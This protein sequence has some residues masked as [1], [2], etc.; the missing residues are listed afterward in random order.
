MNRSTGIGIAVVTGSLLTIAGPA[1]AQ[2]THT[3][4]LAG[5]SF[6]PTDRTINVGDTVH[7]QWLSGLHN[8]ES[9]VVQ[10]SV[11]AHDGNFRSGDPTSAPG[12]TFELTFDAA[13]LAAKP[14]PGNV[15]PYFCIVHA[16][17][18]MVGSITVQAGG[19]TTHSDCDDGDA[20]TQDVCVSGNCQNNAIEGC[21]VT[22]GECDD[23]NPCT[24]DAC[25]NNACDHT[26][27]PDCCVQDGDCQDGNVCTDDV[28]N[29]NV[30]GHTNNTASCDDG[31]SCTTG[32]VCSGGVCAGAPIDCD[33]GNTCTADTCANG[34]CDHAAIPNCCVQDGDCQD[35]NVCTDDVC[36]VNVCEHTNNTASCVDGDT[37]TTG[38]VCSGGV[39]AGA[40]IDCG[41]GDPCT[42]D[43]CVN[44]TCNHAPISD[45]CVQEDDCDDAN[46]CTD[47]GCV[48]NKC[49]H[50]LI[51]D[52]THCTT[53][54]ACDD[55]DECTDDACSNGVC[56]FAPIEGCAPTDGVVEGNDNGNDP[57]TGEEDGQNG[58]DQS[59]PANVN[60]GDDNSMSLS[61]E[62]GDGVSDDLDQCS[63]T[64]LGE[65]VDGNGCSEAQAEMI[66]E[67]APAPLPED[68]VLDV[69]TPSLLQFFCGLFGMITFLCI[70]SG[71][72]GFRA[73]R[74]RR[75]RTRR[76]PGGAP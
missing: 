72:A 57:D 24:T 34:N 4:D 61:D 65:P 49:V 53:A 67:T 26:V 52:C 36:N 74:R 63:D 19:C 2:T 5:I 71:L 46:A 60:G 35:G 56:V 21:C 59:G 16:S 42:A 12:T 15:Y 38:D 3:V 27:I 68:D 75:G 25:V 17:V 40:P 30:C 44:G 62:D 9:G 8:V 76:P 1:P 29:G 31:N 37:C 58:D 64:P 50:V 33:D 54:N 43:T 11:G 47:D 55:G 41:D 48:E 69:P 39:C 20:C 32:D 70:F 22:D 13:F 6:T 7:W 51:A 18:N 14:M 23:T 28:C 10:G 45:C 73:M 66:D